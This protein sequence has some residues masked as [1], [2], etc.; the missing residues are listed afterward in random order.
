M[1]LLNNLPPK[2]NSLAS[3]IVQTITVVNFDMQHVIAAILMEMDLQATCKPL[4]A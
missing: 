4:H 1:I 3:T 2:Y